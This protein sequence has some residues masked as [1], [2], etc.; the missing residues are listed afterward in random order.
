MPASSST[1]EEKSGNPTMTDTDGRVRTAD[2]DK[3]TVVSAK[4][5]YV[6]RVRPPTNEFVLPEEGNLKELR[7]TRAGVRVSKA[8]MDR[9][10]EASERSGATVYVDEVE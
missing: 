3:V 6:V 4:G 9:I 7:V 5:G 8:D 2:Q 10:V 1:A